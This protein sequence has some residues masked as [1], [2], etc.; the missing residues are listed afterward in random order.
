V[1]RVRPT[2]A[3]VSL[4]T[5]LALSIAT[6]ALALR[7]SPLHVALLCA[8]GLLSLALP[9]AEWDAPPARLARVLPRMGALLLL[10]V[11]LVAWLSRSL[12]LLA[13]APSLLPSMTGPLLAPIAIAFAAAPRTF[14]VGRALL[15]A[16]LGILVL[17]GLDPAPS[18]Y[19]GS[20]LPFLRGAEHSAFGAVYLGLSVAVLAA[21]WTATLA[22][23]GPRWRSRDVLKIVAVAAFALALAAT[24]VVGLPALQPRLEQAVASM[25]DQ[26]ATGLSNEST[27]GEFA[28]L[29]VSNRRVLDLRT[30]N[31]TLVPSRLRAQVFTAFDGRAWSNPPT[32]AARRS[33]M[34]QPMPAP[35]GVGPLLDDTGSWFRLLGSG[36]AAPTELRVVQAQVERW[37]L[38]LPKGV[39]AVTV[40]APYVELDRFGFVRRPAGVPS[41]LYGATWPSALTSSEPLSDEEALE[42]LA[43]PPHLDARI[44]DKA[45]ELTGGQRS[46]AE[47]VDAVVGYLQR[48]NIKYTLRPG[49]FHTN[50]PLAEFLFEKKRGYCEYFASAAVV[51][52]RLADVP[53]RFVKGLS[54]GP[55]TD[56]GGGLHVVREK[57]AHA[58]IEV[59]LP[60]KGWVEEDPTPP[61]QFAEAHPSLP[62]FEQLTDRVRAAFASA[63]SLLTERGPVSF[64]R[65]LASTIGRPLARVAREPLAWLVLAAPFIGRWLWRVLRK[66]RNAPALVPEAAPSVPVPIRDLVRDLERRWTAVGRP[67]P[68]GRG[69]LEHARL[70]STDAGPLSPAVAQAGPRIA[71]LYYRSRFG[72]AT[73]ADEDVR[74]LRSDLDAR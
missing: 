45:H 3:R 62:S 69:L 21:L 50:D 65:K 31:P 35:P 14:S 71:A 43:L 67:R 34:L 27:L 4:C 20:L 30:S 61:A 26:G 58:W 41:H 28:E 10:T 47:R 5:A 42:A 39:A 46:P 32:A 73:P 8:F 40:E 23:A 68:V 11:A 48:G 55:N 36:R 72:G 52:L 13:L 57:D 15:P 16:V 64:A 2:L 53:A 63:W 54:V 59:W 60:E 70:L 33:T 19:R 74:A 7:T 9:F 38:M 25:L 56:A 49:P 22:S 37:P 1:R 51:M 29:G 44:V 24:A 66:R 18:G 6:L 17:A 12:S